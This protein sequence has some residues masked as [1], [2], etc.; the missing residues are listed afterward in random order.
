MCYVFDKH[1]GRVRGKK[2][3]KFCMKNSVWFHK[4]GYIITNYGQ[5]N[6]KKTE[7]NK[8]KTTTA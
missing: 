6:L 1:A 4:N 3:G 8:T 5:K 2:M 7:N